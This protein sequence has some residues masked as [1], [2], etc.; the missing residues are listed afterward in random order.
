MKPSETPVLVLGARSGIAHQ[1]ARI[2]AARGHPLMLAARN[3][4]GLSADVSDISIRHGVDVTA[5]EF[6]VLDTS[7][8]GLFLKNLPRQPLIFVFAIGVLG[9]QQTDAEN[10]MSTREIIESNYLAPSL[11]LETVA[12]RMADDKAKASIVAFGSVAGDRG[13]AR[14]YIYGSAKAGFAAY[15]SGLRQRYAGTGLHIMTVKPGFVRTSMTA[16]MTLPGPLT[17]D[18]HDFAKRVVRAM[19]RGD[20]VYYDLRWRILMGVITH[21]P[22]R[23]FMRMKF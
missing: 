19:D 6:D 10:A 22:E 14:S 4:D 1:I 23:L 17:C 5:H 15:L 11:F 18:A 16:H 3:A 2:L 8:H 12:K 9:D 21:I 7:S 20:L 13:R